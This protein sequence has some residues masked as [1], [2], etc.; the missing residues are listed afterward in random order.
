MI[1]KKFLFSESNLTKAANE[2]GRRVILFDTKQPGLALR[3]S[4]TG[5]KTFCFMA[6]DSKRSRSVD[7][8]I[9]GFPKVRLD[10]ARKRAMEL[11]SHL[12][13]GADVTGQAQAERQE[14][15]LDE[16]F[17]RWVE[18]KAAKGRTSHGLDRLRYNKHIKPVF[19]N[20]RVGDIT[21]KQVENWF[22]SLPKKT[23]LSTTSAN[24]L[25]VII[26]TVFNQELRTYTNPCD[27]IG[28]NREES[29]ERFLKPG[30]LPLFFEA[31][32]NQETPDYL[33][34]FVYL[35]LY[36]GA[37]KANLLGMRWADIDFDMELWTIPAA[38]SKNRSSMTVPIIP[39]ALEILSRRWRENQG[40]S[41]PS[42][43]V[44]PSISPKSK[45][46]H[47]H[48]I[49]DS[50]EAMLKRAGIADFRVH[51]LRRSL[52]SW[53]TITGSS[54]AIVGKSL[55]HK[56]QQATAVYA[57]MHLDPVRQSIEK[58]V[59][60]MHKAESKVVPMQRTGN[61]KK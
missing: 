34:D 14:P 27:G 29:R 7:V 10:D 42:T 40:R 56:S 3:I 15:T 43:F 23:G 24:R 51:D 25:L 13:A 53:Q 21:T 1:D 33:R 4:S 9:G 19:G 31:L 37:R 11:S 41:A 36:T 58:A 30:E 61:G 20:R 55:G 16:A 6:W 39:A 8:T 46:G 47:L 38:M 28:L 18:K 35:G 45:T 12:A 26:K 52:G 50:W 22:L 5:T 57:R 59:E 32:D 60:A 48:D 2:T 49:R 54:T 17:E 44:F